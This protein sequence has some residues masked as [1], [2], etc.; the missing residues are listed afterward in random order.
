MKIKFIG[1]LALSTTVALTACTNNE[2]TARNGLKYT[3]VRE[4]SDKASVDGDYLVLNMSY[5]DK[6]TDSV[7]YDTSDN[8]PQV[9]Q[10]KDSIWMAGDGMVQVIFAELHEGDSVTFD[11][12]A[13]DLFS[14]TWKQDLPVNVDPSQVI[15][16]NIGMQRILK[17]DELMTWMQQASEKQR[18][19]ADAEAA[20][21][22]NTDLKIIEEYL[23]ENNIEAT[24]SVSNIYIE[25]IKEGEG[26]FANKGDT[27]QVDYTGYLLD[28]TFFD[29]SREEDAKKNEVYDE[30]RMYK[31]FEFVLGQG[32]VIKGWDEGIADLREGDVARLFIPSTMAY[33]PQQRSA[34]I[35]PNSILVFD[36]E[37]VDVR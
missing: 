26:I 37:L 35:G 9:I 18:A 20:R 32:M 17:Q 22:L 19:R 2:K 36:V 31:P 11:V 12:T 8:M 34:V 10:S 15:Q 24:K 21:Q 4:G 30:N 33:G 14:K 28:G 27:V 7:W 16:F 23:A 3:V 25:K 6:A 13:Q 1:I 29:S 5:R